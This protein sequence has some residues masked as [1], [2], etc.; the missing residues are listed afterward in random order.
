MS[1]LRCFP[2]YPPWRAGP[3][4]LARRNFPPYHPAPRR[5][6]QIPPRTFLAEGPPGSFR[7]ELDPKYTKRE[8]EL[9]QRHIQEHGELPGGS[10][11]DLDELF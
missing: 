9:L 2:P 4:R 3:N 8:G 10:A 11:G 1:A 5:R 6:P 7:G